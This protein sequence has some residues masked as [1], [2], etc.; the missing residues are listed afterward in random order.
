[1]FLYFTLGDQL[2]YYQ[3]INRNNFVIPILFSLLPFLDLDPK[4]FELCVGDLRW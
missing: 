1:M 3:E 2:E 4:L